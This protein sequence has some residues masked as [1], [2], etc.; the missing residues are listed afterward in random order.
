MQSGAPAT[1][2]HVTT[3]RER[4]LCK[5][6]NATAGTQSDRHGRER[7]ENEPQG[8][9]W[10]GGGWERAGMEGRCSGGGTFIPARGRQCQ[11]LIMI[12]FPMFESSL[13]LLS[14]NSFSA[15]VFHVKSL[16][17]SECSVVFR[18]QI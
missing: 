17:Y 8:H 11:I 15:L 5:R 6:H 18:F 14:P 16:Q 1:S 3:E 4:A 10:R 12:Q 7:R 2:E 13:N 9:C